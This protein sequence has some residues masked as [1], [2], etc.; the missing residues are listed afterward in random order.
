[1]RSNLNPFLTM[2]NQM[3]SCKYP[4]NVNHRDSHNKRLQ[5]LAPLKTVTNNVLFVTMYYDNVKITGKVI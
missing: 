2:Y 1:M 5:G 3:K 4:K